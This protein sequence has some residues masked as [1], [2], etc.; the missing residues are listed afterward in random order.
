MISS[1]DRSGLRLW[2]GSEN[3]GSTYR[4]R[5]EGHTGASGG[6]INNPSMV[7]EMIF[8]N[9]TG[10]NANIDVIIGTN[11]NA[12]GWPAGSSATGAGAMSAAS[13]YVTFS[14]V[15]GT[16]T[17]LTWKMTENSGGLIQTPRAIRF[18]CA[19][20]LSTAGATESLAVVGGTGT[21]MTWYTSRAQVNSSTNFARDSTGQTSI[22]FNNTT[23]D[24]A[25][26]RITTD[27]YLVGI[28]GSTYYYFFQTLM[29]TTTGGSMII[30]GNS[31]TTGTITKLTHSISAGTFNNYYSRLYIQGS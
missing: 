28:S 4:I 25:L 7:W 30:Q 1:G 24:T 5:F 9:A 17:R 13:S 29:S 31:S 10:P 19:R 2:Y 14:S 6:D 12:S 11:G 26:R 16:A 27:I 23:A 8:Y 3:S 20:T 15:A 22:I 21:N 18:E